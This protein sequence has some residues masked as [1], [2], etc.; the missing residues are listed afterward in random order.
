MNGRLDVAG[1]SL[2]RKTEEGW[3]S[4]LSLLYTVYSS[5]WFRTIR[6]F[7]SYESSRDI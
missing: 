7:F 5:L 3:L 2:S 4:L 6:N 1:I